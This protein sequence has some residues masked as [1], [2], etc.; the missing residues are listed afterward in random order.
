MEAQESKGFYGDHMNEGTVLVL[1]IAVWI[2]LVVG[3]FV[4]TVRQ[5]NKNIK[6]VSHLLLNLT[7]NQL[8]WHKR[9]AEEIR[10]KYNRETKT[11]NP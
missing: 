2:A 11:D 6:V 4:G 5:R 1:A 8:L 7:D 9:K 10:D 3:I